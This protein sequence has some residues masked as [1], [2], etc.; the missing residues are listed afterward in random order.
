MLSGTP[1]A[2]SGGSYPVSLKAAN[3]VGVDAMQ[4]FTL[5]VHAA[6][7]L[8]SASNAT[9]LTGTSA[10]FNVTTS[11][12]PAAT[13]VRGGVNLPA[14]V[15][16]TSNGDGT[17]SLSG[18]PA[19]GTGGTYALTFTASNS[20]GT[21]FAQQFVLTVHEAPTITSA[22]TAN[23]TV[24][25]AGSFTATAAG[26]PSPNLSMTGTLPSGVTFDSATATLSGT[27]ATGTGGSYP[28]TFQAAN[29]VGTNP[30]QSFV[31]VVRQAPAITS[32]S[33]VTFVARS[34]GSFTVRTSGYP[35][36]TI[37]VG[38]AM[39]DGV[40]FSS[41]SDGT[42]TLSGTPGAATGGTFPLTFTAT[43]A[44]G[45]TPPQSFTLTV[46]EA[47]AITSANSVV[48]TV[49]SAGSF[50]VSTTGFPAPSL[51]ITGALP[52]GVTFDT[53]TRMLS[54]TPAAGSGG[55]YPVTLK[56][57]NG[58]GVDAMQTFTLVVHAAPAL[59]SADNATF[60]TGT[61][62][63]FSV[64]TSGYPAATIVRGGV[65]LPAGV[66]FTSN[67]DGTGSLSGTPAPGTGGTYAITFTANNA[68]GTSAAQNF[69]LTVNEAPTITS[70]ST[71]TF[72]VGKAGSFIVTTGGFPLPIVTMTGALP[73][74]VTFDSASG[75]LS[76]TPAVGSAGSYAL[77]VKAS[78]GIGTHSTQN[79]ILIVQQSPQVTSA[80]NATFV[81]GSSG[82]FS[83]TTDGYPAATIGRGGANLPNGVTFSSNSDGTGTLGG[84]PEPGS[85]GTYALTFTAS[86]T[87]GTSA[88]QDFV[89]TVNES[90]A[91]TSAN[92]AAFTVATA[93][94][95]TVTKS[96]FPAPSLSL[97]G[98]LPS[99]VTFDTST[100]RLSGTP[101]AR[102]GGSYA[103]TFEAANGIGS[104]ATQNFI[105]LVQ[106]SPEITSA[107][108]V[109]FTAG[110]TKSFTVTSTGF[111]AP[112]VNVTGAL[113][114]GVTFAA[115][116]AVLSGTPAAGTGGQ[117]PLFF[118][119]S[120]GVGANAAQTFTLI[121]NEPPIA[122][123]DSLGTFEDTPVNISTSVL[124]SND[125]EPDGDSVTFLNV[126]PSSNASAGTVTLNG[127]IVTY[128]PKAGFIGSDTF[129]YS[130]GDGRGGTADGTVSV[131]ISP[132]SI[133]QIT[134]ITFA[135]GHVL[136]TGRG[137]PG[138]YYIIQS[139]PDPAATFH[140]LSQVLHADPAGEFFYDDTTAPLGIQ[141]YRAIMAP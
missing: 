64:T 19:P 104:N 63:R 36:A 12:Y 88:A 28:L 35:A 15:S 27:P 111:P 83:V 53:S 21:T 59:T 3:G 130:I 10:R 52:T 5:S 29:G 122:I 99:G 73:S 38:G 56:A 31:L 97:T 23:F 91:I 22:S 133:F 40:T 140:D 43:N 47:P 60:L 98:T 18:T 6:P 131:A 123:A 11:G 135:P 118:S 120:N 16:F 72:T 66:S 109:T 80:N 30:T 77:T 7:A 2:G 100:G 41:N 90:P 24:G 25:N 107:N 86:N 116:T 119:A 137:A 49:A 141:F 9:F 32:G 42:G 68:A 76:G 17:G 79:F 94:I 26:F 48:F 87:A 126:T 20:I 4:T 74:G 13:I 106:Q 8:T 95:F 139:A 103:V 57:A 33:S 105:L 124:T 51:Q 75:K 110:T 70:A 128:T 114:S 14:G 37:S 129:T 125:T 112:T 85:G 92:T 82:N 44:A 67:G 34:S 134:E 55:S 50:R 89:L 39:P 138:G 71:A 81:V 117:Y 127:A 46:H 93:G 108:T 102:S 84:I 1:A 69:I 96:G 65:N 78:N 113:P 62:A 121:V 101:V 115:A 132:L 136:L 54:G 61:S 45:T 58:V